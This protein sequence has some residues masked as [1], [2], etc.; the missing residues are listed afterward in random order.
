MT[1]S[2]EKTELLGAGTALALAAGT[3]KV[4]RGGEWCQVYLP[5]FSVAIMTF[6][7]NG[8]FIIFLLY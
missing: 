8:P 5:P 7:S 6:L 3:G 4:G 2:N 1:F